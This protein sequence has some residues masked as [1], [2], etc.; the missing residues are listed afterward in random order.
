[1]EVIKSEIHINHNE[2]N[3]IKIGRNASMKGLQLM[4]SNRTSA[5]SPFFMCGALILATGTF[6]PVVAT[7]RAQVTIEREKRNDGPRFAEIRRRLHATSVQNAEQSLEGRP[8]TARVTAHVGSKIRENESIERIL[9]GLF[10]D[11]GGEPII[12]FRGSTQFHLK[13][14]G[15][16]VKENENITQ[17]LDLELFDQRSS[18]GK[19]LIMK[20]SLTLKCRSRPYHTF[21]APGPSCIWDETPIRELFARLR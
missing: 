4:F 8:L 20:S 7:A 21:V 16:A 17:V 1:L 13:L 14:V 11:V 10:L 18:S 2:S 19:R 5:R 9:S 15:H 3:R 12:D 6:E